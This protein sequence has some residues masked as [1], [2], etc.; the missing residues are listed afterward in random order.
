MLDF[1]F[2]TEQE[3]RA[4]LGKRL[5]AQRLAQGL[6]QAELAE[7]AGISA[8][9]LGALENRG[10]CTLENFIR[11]AMGLGLAGELE[12][13]FALR[14]KSIAQ[15]EQAEQAKRVRAPRKSAFAKARRDAGARM[16]PPTK[17]ES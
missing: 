17:P 11:A 1:G 13:L 16:N 8:N 12:S 3:I 10:Q 9:T 7:R 6:T 5:Q 14:I 4:E 2:A 15:M